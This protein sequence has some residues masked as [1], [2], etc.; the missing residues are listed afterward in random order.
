MQPAAQAALAQR[1]PAGAPVYAVVIGAMRVTDVVVPADADGGRVRVD[2]EF[3]ANVTAGPLGAAHTYFSVER[4]RLGRDAAVRTKPPGQSSTKTCPNCGAPWQASA[5]GSQQ[6]AYCDQ[7]VDN[8]RFDWVVEEIALASLDA[9]PPTLTEEVPERGTDLATYR[10]PE[11]EASW[12]ALTL[13]DGTITIEALQARLRYVYEQLNAA[14]ATNDLTP[15]RAVVSDALYDY[16]TYWTEA[17]RAQGLRNA[18][19]RMRITKIE[20]AKIVRD[21]YFDAVTLRLWGTGLDYVVREPGGDVVRGSRHRE[22]SYSEYWTLVRSAGRRGP[23]RA[24]AGC[25]NCGAPLAVTQAGAC[26]HCGAH[27]TAGEFDWV[28][29]KIEQDDSYRG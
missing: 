18:L 10:Q 21:R 15:A 14:W 22:R 2:V 25:N 9:R 4:W 7:I 3:E 27:V 20:L 5:T 16:L 8:G 26:A 24:D 12:H 11:L 19:E 1:E 13:A 6:C 17:Y 29:S 23:T 28:L